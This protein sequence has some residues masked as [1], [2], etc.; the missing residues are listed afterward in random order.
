MAWTSGDRALKSARYQRGKGAFLPENPM[1]P[2]PESS[3]PEHGHG[4]VAPPP[5]GE[6]LA[7]THRLATLGTLAASIAHEVNNILTPVLS[8]AQ[9]ALAS[10]GDAV[11]TRKALERAVDCTTKASRI[12]SAMLGFVRVESG[13]SGPAS[14]VVAAVVGDALACLGRDLSKDGIALVV[15]IDPVLRVGMDHVSLQQVVLNLL[16]NARAAM[17]GRSGELMIDAK[18]LGSVGV[19]ADVPRGTWPAGETGRMVLRVADTGRGI[20]ANALERVFDPYVS[21]LTYVNPAA[22][23]TQHAAERHTTG[24]GLGLAVCRMLVER[25]GGDI[26]AESV[27]GQGTTF[28]VVLPEAA[29][30]VGDVAAAA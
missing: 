2:R 24:T 30:G 3:S 22:E 11:L 10:P 23:S 28:T 8:Y 18:R 17:R 16:L 15:R 7:R 20:P 4:A 6:D 1:D 26:R 25:A 27:V 12:G 13:G 19:G 29:A 5:L 14:A 9:L 21:T